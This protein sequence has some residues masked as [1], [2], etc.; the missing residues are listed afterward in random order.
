[1][2][3]GLVEDM[4][5]VRDSVRVVRWTYIIRCGDNHY[6]EKIFFVDPGFFDVFS[7]PLRQGDPQTALTD[8]GSI[9]IS[10]RMAEKYFGTRDVMGKTLIVDGKYDFMISGVLADIPSNSHIKASRARCSG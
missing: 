10:A 6:N 1:M 5:E 4:P 9:V 3:P 2:G 7:F 8:P